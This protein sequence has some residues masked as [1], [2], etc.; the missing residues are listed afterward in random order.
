MRAW[1]VVAAV[2][3]EGLRYD[4]KSPCGCDREPKYRPRRRSELRA[5]LIAATRDG[6]PPAETLSRADPLTPT[7]R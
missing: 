2:L 6:L 4:G 1:S 5:R 3:A 7:E